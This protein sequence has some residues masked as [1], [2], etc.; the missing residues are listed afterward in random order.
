MT[1]TNQRVRLANK[2]K[3]EEGE[4]VVNATITNIKVLWTQDK[5]VGEFEGK[6]VSQAMEG[7]RSEVWFE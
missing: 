4:L 6:L 1:R 5:M 3:R 7:H 2:S